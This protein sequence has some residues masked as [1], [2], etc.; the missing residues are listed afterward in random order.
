LVTVESLQALFSSYGTVLDV[1]IKRSTIDKATKFQSGFGFIHYS[2][3]RE[4]IAAAFQAAKTLYDERIDNVNYTC[5]ISHALEK[6]LVSDRVAQA[7]PAAL[8]G[9]PHAASVTASASAAKG[10]TVARARPAAGRGYDSNGSP[11]GGRGVPVDSRPTRHL[12]QDRGGNSHS[13]SHST[14]NEDRRAL[15]SGQ[16]SPAKFFSPN[17]ISDA[18]LSATQ[19]QQQLQ[20]IAPPSYSPQH[21]PL[22]LPPPRTQPQPLHQWPQPQLPLHLPQPVQ[23][24]QQQ[25]KQQQLKHE[26]WQ[27]PPLLSSD[28]DPA[29]SDSED[30]WEQPYQSTSAGNSSPTSGMISSHSCPSRASYDL[31]SC[32]AVPACYSESLDSFSTALDE[33]RPASSSFDSG[34]D[35]SVLRPLGG[36]R[37]ARATASSFFSHDLSA[38]SASSVPVHR[39]RPPPPHSLSRST[40]TAILGP[41]DLPLASLSLDSAPF[42]SAR[43]SGVEGLLAEAHLLEEQSR[44]R[45]GPQHSA[46]GSG[47][48][49]SRPQEGGDSNELFGPPLDPLRPRSGPSRPEEDCGYLSWECR[50]G[51]QWQHSAVDSRAAYSRLERRQRLPGR[52]SGLVDRP[53][54]L[55]DD[56]ASS[57]PG[58]NRLQVGSTRAAQ[59]LHEDAARRMQIGIDTRFVPSPRQLTDPSQAG[60]AAGTRTGVP[61]TSPRLAS[62]LFTPYSLLGVGAR[63]AHGGNPMEVTVRFRTSA[64]LTHSPHHLTAGGEVIDVSPQTAATVLELL[65]QGGA[66]QQLLPQPQLQ[67]FSAFTAPSHSRGQAVPSTSTSSRPP[68]ADWEEQSLSREYLSTGLYRAPPQPHRDIPPQLQDDYSPRKRAEQAPAFSKYSPGSVGQPLLHQHQHHHQHHHM[69]HFNYHHHQQQQQQQQQNHPPLRYPDSPCDMRTCN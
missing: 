21:L 58:R 44:P 31:D 49:R 55:A 26:Q 42:P 52:A 48:G 18:E 8:M 56:S 1:S 20:S 13:H 39:P 50:H 34:L 6:F 47:S 43:E 24:Q 7:A 53:P 65:L 29:P 66:Q 40:D 54:G 51:E 45:R 5:K 15:F 16:L 17:R 33:W 12:D 36:Q 3:Q 9:P 28:W 63:E 35:L 61:L 67:D 37:S 11:A 62:P 32:G 22:P 69:N 10:P 46:L 60:R 27:V 30:T 2:S 19:Q 14:G 68:A 64:A 57:G 59:S 41:F 4:G 25:P 23:Q 38:A